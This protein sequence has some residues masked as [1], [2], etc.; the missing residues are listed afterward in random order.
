MENANFQRD[1]LFMMNRI[2]H[3]AK[4]LVLIMAG[5]EAED[6]TGNLREKSRKN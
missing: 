6:A 5:E 3:A 4:L 1:V 2:L